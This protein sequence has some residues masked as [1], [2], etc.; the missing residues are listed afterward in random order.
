MAYHTGGLT[1]SGPKSSFVVSR[2]KGY[3][4]HTRALLIPRPDA[5]PRHPSDNVGGAGESAGNAGM[6]HI[7]SILISGTPTHGCP[8]LSPPKI[9]QIPA[10]LRYAREFQPS[11]SYIHRNFVTWNFCRRSNLKKKKKTFRRNSASLFSK[12][13]WSK[14]RS[15]TVK[16]NYVH[17]I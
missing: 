6:A 17:K 11:T 12:L 7:V 1:W 5:C 9:P 14:I 8:P 2:S 10:G 3:R 4:W 16:K 13:F 15:D